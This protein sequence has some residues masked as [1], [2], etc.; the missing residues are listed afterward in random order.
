[1]DFI[2]MCD[3]R[4]KENNKL[5]DEAKTGDEKEEVL[6]DISFWIG[7]RQKALEQLREEQNIKLEK[8]KAENKIKC[9]RLT[10]LPFP[11]QTIVGLT[12][13]AFGRMNLF[14]IIRA[15]KDGVL[16]SKWTWPWATPK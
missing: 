5:L 8:Q 14:T 12:G 4:I 11:G 16:P 2:K 13:H 10:A 9:E 15:E 3:E 6:N 7:C 1:M